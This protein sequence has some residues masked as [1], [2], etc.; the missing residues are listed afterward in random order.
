MDGVLKKH[1]NEVLK[2]IDKQESQASSLNTNTSKAKTI[3]MKNS[4]S[5]KKSMLKR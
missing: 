4:V 3:K 1:I 2:F 5:A